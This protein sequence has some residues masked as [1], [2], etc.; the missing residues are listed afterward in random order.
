MNK[1]NLR[2]LGLG[3]LVSGAILGG[4]TLFAEGQ[5]HTPAT[6]TNESSQEDNSQ[7]KEEIA[8]LKADKEK[9][10]SE[11]DKLKANQ[12]STDSD[13]SDDKQSRPTVS[14]ADETDTSSGEES[15]QNDAS[16]NDDSQSEETSNPNNSDNQDQLEEPQYSGSFTISDGE[17]ASD[18]AQRLESEGY[19]DSATELEDLI[20]QWDLST[21][22]VADTYDLNSDMSIHDIA[23]IITQGAYYY[24]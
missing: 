5:P 19:I 15:S 16:Q 23:S 10:E 3:F 8:S 17:N 20:D 21:V 2:S 7:Y 22:I 11:N 13:N 12:S 6:N 18:I 1:S 24:Y 14:S 9:L 4:Y